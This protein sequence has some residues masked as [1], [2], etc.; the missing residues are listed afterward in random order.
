MRKGQNML[1]K[2]VVIGKMK[3]KN[4]KIKCEELLRFISS[5]AKIEM[6]EFQDSS[7]EKEG[8]AL[9]RQLENKNDYVIVL[10]E[11]GK[12]LSSREFAGKIE[13]I[14]RRL[15]FVIG[16]AF[17]LSEKVKQRADFLWSLSP[18]TFTHEIARMLLLEQIFRANSI[19]KK[20]PYHH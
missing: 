19:I 17:G 13:T 7:V 2:I 20:T 14:N 1:V 10:S 15:V 9:L 16:G 18:L 4:L 3:D 6:F 12:L 11:E 5:F 8:D